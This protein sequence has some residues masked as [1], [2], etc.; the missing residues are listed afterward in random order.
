MS[1]RLELSMYKDNNEGKSSSINETYYYE[2][3]HGGNSSEVIEECLRR[4]KQWKLYERVSDDYFFVSN[5]NN[6]IDRKSV[7]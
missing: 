4:R 7:V 3:I 1:I 5:A 2:I 6:S